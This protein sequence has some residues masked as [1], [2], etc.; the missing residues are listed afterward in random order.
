MPRLGVINNVLYKKLNTLL[1]KHDRQ[2]K[3]FNHDIL[4]LYY[5]N[6]IGENIRNYR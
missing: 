2:D 1:N 5:I 4:E 3:N 6:Q